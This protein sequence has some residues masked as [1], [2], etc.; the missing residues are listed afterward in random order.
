MLMRTI[1]D[2]GAV[3]RDARKAQG[4]TQAALAAKLGTVQDWISNLE[5]GRL[6]N[7]GLG[8]ILRACRVLGIDIY[9]GTNLKFGSD[10]SLDTGELATG[11]PSFVTRGG[12]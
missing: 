1:R 6:D 2:F 12:R 11:E 3:I 8:A 10:E 5:T 9:A 7:P 4:M